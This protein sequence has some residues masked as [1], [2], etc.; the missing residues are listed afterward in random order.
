MECEQHEGDCESELLL[1]RGSSCRCISKHLLFL[2][3]IAI[4]SKTCPEA[5]IKHRFSLSR[6]LKAYVSFFIIYNKNYSLHCKR[7][8][9]MG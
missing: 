9:R 2:E 7:Y 6:Y 5:K 8:L 1:G 3:N 4:E